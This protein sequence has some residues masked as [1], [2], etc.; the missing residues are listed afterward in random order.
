MAWSSRPPPPPVYFLSFL[1]KILLKSADSGLVLPSSRSPAHFFQFLI[2]IRRAFRPLACEAWR[3]Q[4]SSCNLEK[5]FFKKRHF[6]K[7]RLGDPIF[8][9]SR[10]MQKHMGFEHFWPK[11]PKTRPGTLETDG[12]PQAQ[13]TTTLSRIRYLT[14][15]NPWVFVAFQITCLN[16]F[17]ISRTFFAKNHKFLNV[18]TISHTFLINYGRPQA[19]KTTTLSRIRYL[20]FKNPWVFVAF[21][22]T[23]SN[24]FTISLTFFA[25]NLKFS[26][27]STISLTFLLNSWMY[28][29]F[30]LL[31]ASVCF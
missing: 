14:F 22:I 9:V 1:I 17:T 16:V 12:R 24:V 19:Q 30:W 27:V 20:T 10:N 3:E 31:L 4:L 7:K 2:K 26:N 18:S 8:K 15:K 5:C 28:H 11:S 21:Q 29:V 23:C 13:K 25:K 6:Q